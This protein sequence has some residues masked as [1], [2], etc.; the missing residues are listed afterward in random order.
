MTERRPR[1]AFAKRASRHEPWAP[2]QWVPPVADGRAIIAVA[3]SGMD[4]CP[5]L[6]RMANA[7]AI[8]GQRV[9]LVI[10]RER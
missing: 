1:A 10:L 9:Q 6:G 3:D 7:A 4:P 5:V 8:A 2:K